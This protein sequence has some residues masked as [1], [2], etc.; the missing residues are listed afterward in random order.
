MRPSTR[1]G[2]AWLID[3]LLLLVFVAIGRASHG[4]D[5]GGYALTLLPFLVGLQ[6]GWLLAGRG[7][8]FAVLRF[9]GVVWISTLVLGMLLRAATGQG[10]APA[11]V[12]VTVILLAVSFLGWRLLVALVLRARSSP[13]AIRARRR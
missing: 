10:I 6:S 12:V 11:F 4:E 13:S 1:R 2:I 5:A 7:N 9:G 3:L 8:P